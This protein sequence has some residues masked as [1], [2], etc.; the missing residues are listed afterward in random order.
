LIPD[1]GIPMTKILLS[2]PDPLSEWA[3]KEAA[4]NNFDSVGEYVESLLQQ[5]RVRK[6]ALAEFDQLV[7]EGLDSGISERTM[8]EILADARQQA[9]A[10]LNAKLQAFQA[11]RS[12][13]H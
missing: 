10:R 5:E 12:R 6:D 13:P 7:Q 1:A 9:K 4:N 8:D 2:L 11:S 3:E